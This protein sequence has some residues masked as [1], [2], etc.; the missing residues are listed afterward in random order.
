MRCRHAARA[1]PRRQQQQ[2]AAPA[3]APP[4]LPGLATQVGT[5]VKKEPRNPDLG[6]TLGLLHKLDKTT[7]LKGK[8]RRAPPRL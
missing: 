4:P 7:V 1:Q 2:P 6:F 3:R 8:A 5:E